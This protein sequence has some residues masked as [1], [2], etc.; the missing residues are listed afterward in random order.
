MKTTMTFAE[1][2]DLYNVHTQHVSP[3]INTAADLILT[4]G[5]VVPREAVE[6]QPWHIEEIMLKFGYTRRGR[7]NWKRKT[8][9]D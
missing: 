3:N 1:H 7:S 9:A 8:K 6:D 4:H 5:D 2:I